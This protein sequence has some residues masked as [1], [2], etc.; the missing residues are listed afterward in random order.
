MKGESLATKLN[1]GQSLKC[2]KIALRSCEQILNEHWKTKNINSRKVSSSQKRWQVEAS[3]IYHVR[4]AV[5]STATSK[6]PYSYLLQI[7]STSTPTYN[8]VNF[9]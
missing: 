1:C 8:L 5:G 3:T 2:I 7:W 4:L 9:S 6:M